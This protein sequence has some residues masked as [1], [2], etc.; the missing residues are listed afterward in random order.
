MKTRTL[1][2]LIALSLTTL[3]AAV[4]VR[5]SVP[6]G[7]YAVVEKVVLE[8][9]D[10]GAQRVQIWGVFAVWDKK[11]DSGYRSP[12]RG[13][14][15]YNCSREQLEVCRSEWADLKSMAG[16]SQTIG[17]GSRSL[18]TGRVRPADERAAAADSYPIQFGMVRLGSAR[19]A[20][21]DK[22]RASARG[23]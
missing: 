20:I 7:V 19:G 14:L 3:A 13:Y 18:G 2:V 1:V 16:T 10:S 5:A 15:Y 6:V 11:S 9:A 22:L 23:E 12:E 4:T 17:F 21:F 8:P